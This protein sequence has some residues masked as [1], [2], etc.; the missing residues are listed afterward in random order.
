MPKAQHFAFKQEYHGLSFKLI[1]DAELFI[2]SPGRLGRKGI[3][4]KALWDTGASGT[5]ITPKVSGALN[6]VPI[7]RIKVAGVNN[8]SMADVVEVSIGLPNMVMVEDINVMICDLKQD[9][10]LLIGMDII[11]LGDF[12]I[13]N[14]GGKTLFSFVIPPFENRTDHYKRALAVNNAGTDSL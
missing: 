5:V 13:S 4:V 8:I 2:A 6:L 14:W 11:L 3:K 7:D 12:A 1:T 10:D 9:I